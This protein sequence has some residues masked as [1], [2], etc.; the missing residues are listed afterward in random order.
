MVFDVDDVVLGVGF[1]VGDGVDGG[2]AFGVVE[3][4]V[5]GFELGFEGFSE[6]FGGGDL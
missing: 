1:G 2:D 3:V 4:D 5:G 6:G